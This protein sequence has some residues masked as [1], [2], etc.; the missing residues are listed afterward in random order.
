MKTSNHRTL[1]GRIACMLALQ[2]CAA[3]TVDQASAPEPAMPDDLPPG[4]IYLGGDTDEAAYD[5]ADPAD[6]GKAH[7]SSDVDKPDDLSPEEAPLA[8]KG[9]Y[10]SSAVW[11]RYD[12]PVC[13]ETSGS[14]TEKGWV[15]AKIEST[16]EA[17]SGVDFT[18]WG[19]CASSSRGIRIK[20]AD[21]NPRTTGL[22]SRIDGVSGG[23]LL[24]FTF[25]SWNPSCASN[26]QNC[27]ETIAMHEFGH[28]LGIAH[29]HNRPDSWLSCKADPQGTNGD[30]TVGG[31]DSA[32]IMNYCY[33]AS[34]SGRLSAG[35]IATVQQM[36]PPGHKQDVGV[37]PD[38]DTACPGATETIY[39][40]DE[41]DS[42]NN[43]HS[44]WNG[45]W[46]SNKNTRMTFCR[47]AGSSLKHFGT[48]TS[49][50]H[51][52][53][54]LRLGAT[55][56]NGSSQFSRYF[57]NE[58][59][60]NANWKIGD[61]RPSVSGSGGT[62]LEFCVFSGSSNSAQRMTALPSLGFSYG[63]LAAPEFTHARTYGMVRTDDED[64]SNNNSS[65][66]TSAGTNM[67]VV[68]SNTQMHL[69]RR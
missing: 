6:D 18:G 43:S 62:R 61:I 59:D 48:T 65:S 31:F 50:L 38:A 9:Y 35:D 57:D 63:V 41:D 40:D 55:C 5:D 39:M 10:L 22:G 51:D 32:S 19:T 23:M 49:R 45:S 42:N 34:Y 17:N 11:Q 16:W 3:G 68:G 21:A 1:V 25:A 14:A 56:P 58:D 30:T 54:V 44:G 4:V 52:Y 36:Y 64:D 26:R 2:A 20:I 67:I 27:I 7:A 24:D 47:V 69:W 28:A 13:W 8:E 33:S 53:A 66:G 15:K 12:I 46:V 60:N 29:E 37:I